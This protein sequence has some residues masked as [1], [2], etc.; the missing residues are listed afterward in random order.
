LHI[1]AQ[2]PPVPAELL[3]AA[4]PLPLVDDAALDEALLALGDELAAVAPPPP[5]PVVVP[6]PEP[7]ASS[8]TPAS[9]PRT[10]RVRGVAVINR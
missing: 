10:A 3:D 1:A 8:A 7:Q 5:E 2:P 4:P 6:A 9:D